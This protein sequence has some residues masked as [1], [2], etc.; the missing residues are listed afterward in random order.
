VSLVGGAEK[1]WRFIRERHDEALGL[2][3][4]GQGDVA[5]A[6]AENRSDMELIES[7]EINKCRR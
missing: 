6:G 2:A 3:G 5:K 7:K 1:E 4:E